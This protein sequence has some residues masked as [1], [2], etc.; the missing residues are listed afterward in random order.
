MKK[1]EIKPEEMIRDLDRAIDLVS[2][3]ENIDLEKDNLAKFKEKIE[4]LDT[5]IK[6]KYKNIIEESDNDLDSKE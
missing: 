4:K 1:S 3:V 5:K 2:Q 6:E